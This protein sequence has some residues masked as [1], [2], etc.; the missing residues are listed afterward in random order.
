MKVSGQI[1]TIP[2]NEMTTTYTVES[3]TPDT[4]YTVTVSAL[5]SVGAGPS[6]TVTQKT[7]APPGKYLHSC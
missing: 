5:T 6:E 4:E 2:V 1:D 7:R 3:L